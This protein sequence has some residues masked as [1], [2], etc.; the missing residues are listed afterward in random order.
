MKWYNVGLKDQI[1]RSVKVF[2]SQVG[3]GE[4]VGVSAELN[5]FGL[6]LILCSLWNLFSIK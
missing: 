6:A 1:K 2:D 4:S 3:S 5:K